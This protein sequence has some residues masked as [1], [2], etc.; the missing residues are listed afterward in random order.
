MS[1]KLAEI[2]SHKR[3]E[4]EPLIQRAE[5]LRYAALERNEFKSLA[6]AIN[7]GSDRLGLIAEV[8]KAS[9][10]AGII[11]EDFDPVSQAKKYADAGASA[12]SVLTDEKYFGGSLADLWETTDFLRE[13]GRP[14][15]C[16]RKDFM[17]HPIQVT[18]AAEAG[19]RAI[20]II[21][22]ALSEDEMKN[23]REAADLAGLDC[24]YEI[25]DETE[26][27]QVLPH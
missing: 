26:L 21:V 10:S 6:S 3:Q 4:I 16:L 20:L 23:L 5:K 19:A 24:L 14:L 11:T 9:P 15:P 17:V 22:R 2:V 8:K 1:D 18:E 25:H 27:E 13:R 12:I 7:V